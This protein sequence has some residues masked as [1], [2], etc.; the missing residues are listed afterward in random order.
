MHPDLINAIKSIISGSLE[1]ARQCLAQFI[2]SDSSIHLLS[3]IAIAQYLLTYI[4]YLENNETLAL[5]HYACINNKLLPDKTLLLFLISPQKLSQEAKQLSNSAKI[6]TPIKSIESPMS[7]SSSSSNITRQ[8]GFNVSKGESQ[9]VTYPDVTSP[10]HLTNSSSAKH[11]E[12]VK[13]AD[14]SQ[15]EINPTLEAFKQ[16]N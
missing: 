2:S 16:H 14:N 1:K 3:E 15:Q 13:N 10:R 5:Q 6:A 11:I 7:P 4:Y 8:L 12:P 9:S